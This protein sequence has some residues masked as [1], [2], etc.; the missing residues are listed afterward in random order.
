MATY[1]QK[2]EMSAFAVAD[3]LVKRLE[4]D[5]Y[6]VVILNFAN[7]DMVGHTGILPAAIKAVETVDACAGQGG[8]KGAL[9]GWQRAD[10]RRPWQCRADGR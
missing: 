3:E 1:D 8:G 7:C 2:P 9:T 10:H 6:D 5:R 4:Q